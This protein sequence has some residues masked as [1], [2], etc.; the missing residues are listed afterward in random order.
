MN[1]GQPEGKGTFPEDERARLR[2]ELEDI[3]PAIFEK[4]KLMNGLTDVEK[5]KNERKSIEDLEKRA[6][7]IT[8]KLQE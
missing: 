3:Y 4:T 2:K 1:Q 6:L 8:A 7:E 5:I